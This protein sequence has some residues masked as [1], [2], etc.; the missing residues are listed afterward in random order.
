[1]TNRRIN[2]TVGLRYENTVK[3]AAIVIAIRE[4]LQKKPEID[5]TQSLLIYS[6]GFGES[7]LTIT[8]YCFNAA[9]ALQCAFYFLNPAAAGLGRKSADH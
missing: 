9:K 4:M 3:V 8:V 5:Q 7:S 6:D 1:M 2:A